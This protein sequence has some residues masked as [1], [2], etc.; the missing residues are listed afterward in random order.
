MQ[1][2][3]GAMRTV[4]IAVII[5]VLLVIV[6]SSYTIVDP[7]HRGVVVM[8][9]RVEDT[10]LGEG[11]HLILPP[12]VR[13]VVQADVRT[14]KIEIAAE[15]ASMDLQL[16]QVRG[17]L[18]Y[19]VDPLAVNRLYQ[20]VGSDY[21]NIVIV[22][23]M[24]EAIKAATAQY[25]VENI[26][27]QRAEIRDKIVADLRERLARTHIIVDAFS[28]ADVAFSDE[29][30]RAIERKQVAEQEALQKQYELQSAERDVEIQLALAEG[31]KK[32]AIIAAEGRAEARRIE[33]EVEAEALSLIAAQLRNN[34][35]LIRYEWATRL[36]P[37]VNTI[38][39]PSEQAI[40]LD[41]DALVR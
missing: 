8:L 4:G 40:I 33:A 20:E 14:K 30:D 11:F 21:E 22:P 34:E 1:G 32:A 12:V 28:L 16:L 19:H 3:S 18:N 25:R 38:L 39:L 17:I 23:G 36:S 26:L 9:G 2:K 7:G 10:V 5:V 24:Q 27:V 35:A 41:S 15:A 31:E 6:F 13:Q 37:T 29:F